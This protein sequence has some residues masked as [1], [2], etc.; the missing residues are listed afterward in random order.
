MTGEIL[1]TDFIQLLLFFFLIILA[2]ILMVSRFILVRRRTRELIDYLEKNELNDELTYLRII[3]E[4]GNR[5]PPFSR[6]RVFS[7]FLRQTT[8]D[9]ELAKIKIR[10][11]KTMLWSSL[12]LFGNFV[13]IGLLIIFV[14]LNQQ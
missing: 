14:Y 3:D 7:R 6:P 2:L 13:L 10:T 5:Q 9:S 4:A 12:L 8:S 1:I 11:R